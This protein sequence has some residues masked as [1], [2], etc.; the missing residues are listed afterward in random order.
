[1]PRWIFGNVLEM[2]GDP[3]ETF[4][5]YR[6][7]YGGVFKY[8]YYSDPVVVVSDPALVKAVLNTQSDAFDK[9]RDP[10]IIDVIGNGLLLTNGS[11]WRRQR[12][13][14]SPTF[15]STYIKRM[16]PCFVEVTSAL[17][18]TWEA[19]PDGAVINMH[20]YM[21]KLTL[22]VIGKAG[23][24]YEFNALKDSKGELPRA[25]TCILHETESRIFQVLP[26]W[27][28]PFLPSTR[29]FRQAKAVLMREIEGMVRRRREKAKKKS[30]RKTTSEEKEGKEAKMGGG[31]GAEDQQ[32]AEEG[33]DLGNAKDL[34]GRLLAA[35]DP[36]TG[37]TLSDA[38]LADELI[39]FL[40]AGHETTAAS[41]AF[42][43]YLL[44][45]HKDVEKRLLDEIH[46]IMGNR[47]QPTYEDL[48]KFK[49]LPLIMKE[50][51]RLYPS[52]AMQT[53]RITNKDVALTREDQTI[54][55][56]KGTYVEVWPW[57][58]HR[59]PDLW[60]NPLEFLPE[61]FDVPSS[62]YAYKYIPFGEGPR[63]CIGQKLAVMESKVVL[64]MIL[65]RFKLRMVKGA[66]MRPILSI[67]LR[68]KELKMVVKRRKGKTNCSISSRRDTKGEQVE[69][70]R[71]ELD[72]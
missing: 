24:G 25:V 22:E 33:E 21:T 61:R 60:E 72:D 2:M 59:A 9:E 35:E 51:M 13:I 46:S 6:Q 36:D 50:S 66:E 10:V 52:V 26:W 29:K 20:Q 15:G 3:L 31:G 5:K 43:F 41:L 48:Q 65:Q 62:A 4:L 67:T 8:W 56:P 38:Q 12:K 19:L 28:L 55:L 27:K 14:M 54:L 47:P 39:T 7:T 58:L 63:N 44:S 70:K 64:V 68:P 1:V 17:V 37:E 71:E 23:F 53:T 30:E 42:T 18:D 11:F 57:L 49:Y 40:I 32:E 45:Q 16:V 34:L 69:E